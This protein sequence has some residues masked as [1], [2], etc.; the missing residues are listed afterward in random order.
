MKKWT[1]LLF[2]F[3]LMT[4]FFQNCSPVSFQSG[5]SFPSLDNNGRGYGGKPDGNYY[6]FIPNFRC[7]QKESPV[8]H[9]KIEAEKTTLTEN[10][11][12]LCGA[13]T[14]TMDT[15]LIDS[16][17]YQKEIV[18]YQESIFEGS[19]TLPSKIPANLV[20]IWCRDRN[21]EQGIET[22]T[23]FNNVSHEAV[24]RI[25]FSNLND[26]QMIP[27]FTVAR[28]IA[29][30]TIVV[31]DDRGFE[32]MVH[33]DQP[34]QQVGLFKAELT[35][36]IQGQKISRNTSC[37]LGGTLDPKV[38][39]AQQTVDFDTKS[40]KISPDRNH[41][42][43]AAAKATGATNLFSAR[44][45][46]SAQSQVGPDLLT[47]GLVTG[48]GGFKFSPDSQWLI[49][50]GDP[51]L[52]GVMELFKA[53][54][55]GS[56]IVPLRAG[57]SSSRE[58]VI[59]SFKIQESSVI[60]VESQGS[61]IRSTSIAGGAPADLSPPP[62]EKGHGFVMGSGPVVSEDKIIYI[63][64]NFT[65]NEVYKARID[66][67]LIQKVTPPFSTDK[68]KFDIFNDIQ[69]LADTK[70]AEIRLAS[71]NAFPSFKNYLVAFDDSESI[72]LPDN[73]IASI[74]SP[75]ATHVLLKQRYIL[76][77]GNRTQLLS[78]TTGALINIPPIPNSK[79]LPD[80]TR[81]RDSI[82]FTRDSGALIMPVM[83]DYNGIMKAVSISTKD[84][85]VTN[86]CPGLKSLALFIQEDSP[87]RYLIS[88]FD[89]NSGILTIYS[90]GLDSSCR[91]LNSTVAKNPAWNSIADV[92]F[93]PDRQKLLVKLNPQPGGSTRIGD[94]EWLTDISQS[95]LL[96]IPLDG[97]PALTIDS[98]VFEAAGI[99]HASFLSDSRRVMFRGNQIR[100]N[101]FHVFLWTAP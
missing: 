75:D 77:E 71:I 45:D 57:Q 63:F 87:N 67:S 15:K 49:Y 79:F 70:Y 86:L 46:G 74:A 58:S 11:K 48:L 52:S 95:Q 51:R 61:T 53:N 54:L 8:A 101:E 3:M 40:F 73:T 14:L 69:V 72:E 97:K 50:N 41:L 25:Y 38:W 92:S 28:T 9:L 24:N 22:I 42:A 33:R 32:L 89:R 66:G 82:F 88:A 1:A 10:K 5:E 21:D 65:Q 84:G 100:P 18:G 19:S 44:M 85:T 94:E 83:L 23:H 37:R 20:E 29:D 47:D 56:I 2:P 12:L 34:A 26:Q 96:Y 43:F 27:D 59:A 68:W 60:F 17:I 7:E 98:P 76:F 39:P 31:K 62:S 80:E 90:A 4:L 78:T 13:Q 30:R 99:T 35:A 64:G 6:H 55:N 81:V 36:V 16:S 91:K 93:S